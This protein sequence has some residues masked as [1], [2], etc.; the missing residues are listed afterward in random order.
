MD[1]DGA[2]I[3]EE[4]PV[5]VDG[6]AVG[7]TRLVL[8]ALFRAGRD[9]ESG[10]VVVAPPHPLYGGSMESPVVTEIAYAAADAGL[11]SLRFDWRGVGGSHGEPS[12]EVADHAADYAAALRHLG[13]TV[14]GPLCAAGYSAGAA[15]AA[16]AAADSRVTRL[17][18]VAPPP[19]MLDA[20]RLAAFGGSVLV[21]VG[22]A[23]RLAPPEALRA[24][25]AALPRWR[26]EVLPEADHFFGSGLGALGRIARSWLG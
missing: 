14:R 11:A 12:G 19:S 6:P 16:R 23:D 7:G 5:V 21:V 17:L 1:P 2:R 26:L 18:L 10:G 25:L 22:E 8:D 13:E 15:A 9:R 24:I 20:A 4:R 3:A